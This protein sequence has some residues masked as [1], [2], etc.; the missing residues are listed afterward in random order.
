[1]NYKLYIQLRPIMAALEFVIQKDIEERCHFVV[2]LG[3]SRL[4]KSAL[5]HWILRW[6]EEDRERCRHERKHSV[7]DE[8][9]ECARV[10]DACCESDV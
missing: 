9:R 6:V 10:E 5:M 8:H 4:R 2:Y 1:M 3:I 7:Q